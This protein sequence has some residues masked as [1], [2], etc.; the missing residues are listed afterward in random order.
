MFTSKKDRVFEGFI[1]LTLIIVLITALYP[2]YY[3]VIAS[4]SD[5][6]M[7]TGGRVWLFPRN[8]TMDSYK[9]VFANK[10]IWTGYSNTIIYTVL[11]TSLDLAVTITCAY[12]LSKKRLAGKNMIMGIFVF[13]MYFNGGLIPNYILIKSL[14]WVDT[15]WV[16]IIPG[17]LS[18]YNM[19]ITRTFYQNNVPDELYEAARIDGSTEI[20]MFFRIVIPLSA[21]IIAVMALFYGVGHWNQFFNA[22]IYLNDHKLFPLQLILR[23]ILLMNQ[24]MVMDNMTTEQMD[25]IAR[26]A[27]LAETMKYAL[28]F[29][30]S[31]PVLVIYP[32]MQKYFVKGVMIGAIKG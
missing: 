10:E 4:I 8:I 18:V 24:Q 19:I 27:Q 15:L 17:A 1:N 22:M 12:A 3:T 29:I 6:L 28:I 25:S 26:R 11:A 23:N 30:S 13:T 5:P 9:N 32:F 20:G 7:V 14:G 16:M 31:F 21:P 2:L